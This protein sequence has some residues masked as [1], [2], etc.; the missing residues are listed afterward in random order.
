M[1][2]ELM[3]AQFQVKTSKELHESLLIASKNNADDTVIVRP[4]IYIGGFTFNSCD[5]KNITIKK[6]NNINTGHVV[7][8]GKNRDKILSIDLDNSIKMKIDNITFR[9]SIHPIYSK[10]N[11]KEDITITNCIFMGQSNS[12]IY[13]TS[14]NKVSFSYNTLSNTKIQIQNSSSH[15]FLLSN[16]TFTNNSFKI[17]DIQSVCVNVIDNYIV[18][19]SQCFSIHAQTGRISGNIISQNKSSLRISAR[20][21]V[22]QNNIV[23]NNQNASSNGGGGIYVNSYNVY[24]KNNDIQDNSTS[25]NGGGIFIQTDFTNDK[26][27][28]T[29]VLLSNNI[30]R[31]NSSLNGGGIY[32]S[33]HN[34]LYFVNNTIVNNTAEHDG[35]GLYLDR[36]EQRGNNQSFNIYNN[37]IYYNESGDSGDD[38]F[39]WGYNGITNVYNN[40]YKNL[41]GEIENN[42]QNIDTSPLFFNQINNDYYLSPNSPCVDKGNNNAPELPSIDK[43]GD[44]RINNNI[45][46]IGAYEHSTTITHPADTNKD[47]TIT[48]SEFNNYNQ[49]W[50]NDTYWQNN[51]TPVAADYLTRAGYIL[52]K[53]GKYKNT[54]ARKPLCWEPEN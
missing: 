48:Q 18:N 40:N 38:I 12:Y 31:N 44:Q 49:A 16:C 51:P 23:S 54:G 30:I 24:L 46:D 11:G 33:P 20:E 1:N 21:I 42:D 27:L 52:Q 14:H 13:F 22:I 32:I 34:Q 47:Y 25:G 37:I 5:D 15:F 50:R 26:N 6:D 8:D 17:G 2:L 7:F 36:S 45:V 9:N 28:N 43:D 29:V 39:I 35:G 10:A 53:G 3:A 4:G 19:N 41:S